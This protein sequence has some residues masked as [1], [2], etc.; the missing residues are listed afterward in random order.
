M[1]EKLFIHPIAILSVVKKKNLLTYSEEKKKRTIGCLLGYSKKYK[2][3]CT[4]SFHIPFEEEADGNSWFIDHNFIE[5]M[6]DMY[7]KVNTKEFVIGWY[8]NSEKIN[9]ND[10]NINKIISGYIEYPV[11]ILIWT[12]EK[13]GFFIDA[14]IA[15]NNFP[16]CETFLYKIE[17]TIGL[18]ES[19]EIG[20]FQ[21][22]KNSCLIRNLITNDSIKNFFKIFRFYIS[23]INKI[24][25]KN[26]NK[27]FKSDY[28]NLKE[29]QN[30]LEKIFL[31]LRQDNL[32]KKTKKSFFWFLSSLLKVSI[33]IEKKFLV[34][35][36]KN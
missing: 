4:S 16:Q 15:K 27:I 31:I 26:N 25:Q 36:N 11:Q 24:I 12:T 32:N 9:K 8:S 23:H 22:L 35:L 3:S 19:E 21:I 33:G 5:K 13:K 10:I 2:I 6:A 28:T 30:I 29:F 7:K 14:F 18:L 17:V 1:I 20:I 34:L